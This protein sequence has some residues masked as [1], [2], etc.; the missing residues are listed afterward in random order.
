MK[1]EEQKNFMWAIF[2]NGDQIFIKPNNTDE[3]YIEVIDKDII[4]YRIPPFFGEPEQVGIYNTLI[5][6]I[7]AANY[8]A[9]E[10]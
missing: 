7:K 1:H 9:G 10:A 5:E 8:F 6:A 4:L 2:A 3:Y